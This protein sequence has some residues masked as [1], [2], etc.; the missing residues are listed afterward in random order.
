MAGTFVSSTAAVSAAIGTTDVTLTPEIAG[1][2]TLLVVGVAMG[3]LQVLD[4]VEYGGESMTKYSSISDGVN[5]GLEMYYTIAPPTSQSVSVKTDGG[6]IGVTAANFSGAHQTTP[7]TADTS[8]VNATS[9]YTYSL[10]GGAGGEVA[11]DIIGQHR[12]GSTNGPFVTTQV[13]QVE[14]VE[15]IGGDGST[16]MAGI[17]QSY[18]AGAASVTFGWTKASGLASVNI[19]VLIKAAEIGLSRAIKY[20]HN[21]NDPGGRI[22]DELG[23][24][25]PPWEVKPNNWI[26]VTGL[27]LP[28]STKYASFTKDPE[29]AY[30][31]EVTF[32][33]T[34]GLRI[35]TNRGEMTEVLLA[36]A[37]GGKTL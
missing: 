5:S 26:R 29:L 17:S 2:N 27:F 3:A 37:A 8:A 35:K 34:G 24:V 30:I 21:I 1:D 23:R 19:A 15:A 11:Y 9:D 7:F 6:F 4:T 12:Y 18:I 20:F 13:G 33:A 31:E 16:N 36:R 10:S 22:Y 14:G 25:V 28:T 32:S